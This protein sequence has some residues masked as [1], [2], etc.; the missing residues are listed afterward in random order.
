[1]KE[2][3]YQN[4]EDEGKTLEVSL[5]NREDKKRQGGRKTGKK[6]ANN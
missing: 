1:M 4:K 5:P 2:G 3:K 6:N